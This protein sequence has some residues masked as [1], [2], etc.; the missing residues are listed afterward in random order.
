MSLS[1]KPAISTSF[2]TRTRL[3]EPIVH[4]AICTSSAGTTSVISS[5]SKCTRSA[6]MSFPLWMKSSFLV[7]TKICIR[8]CSN[9]TSIHLYFCMS[10]TSRQTPDIDKARPLIGGIGENAHQKPKQGRRFDG[11]Q[12]IAYAETDRDI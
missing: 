5:A 2:T 8:L 9:Q 10:H 12:R 3:S 11:D 4:L 7:T 1:G 6:S